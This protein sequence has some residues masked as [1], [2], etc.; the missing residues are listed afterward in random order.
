MLLAKAFPCGP[1][2]HAKISFRKCGEDTGKALIPKPTA[3]P[4][5]LRSERKSGLAQKPSGR[6][7]AGH[8]FD[9]E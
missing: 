9:T 7:G 1:R 2:R 8:S 5:A 4:S 3:L 6:K